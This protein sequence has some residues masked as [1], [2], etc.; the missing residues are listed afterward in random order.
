MTSRPPPFGYSFFIPL[1]LITNLGLGLVLLGGLN[2]E[3]WSGWLRLGTGAF[4]CALG[5]ALAATA[6][7]YSYWSRTMARQI[8]L[9]RRIAD[10]F[11][12]WLEDVRLPAEALRSLNASLDEVMAEARKPKVN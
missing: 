11:F 9:W 6:L 8:A 1:G 2:P 3:G 10:T 5:G 4:C 7:S 12:T